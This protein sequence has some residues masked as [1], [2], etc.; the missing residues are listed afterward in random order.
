MKTDPKVLLDK[1]K[2]KQLKIVTP[3]AQLC[4]ARFSPDGKVLVAGSF[5]GTVR[6]FDPNADAFTELPE[7][8]I[9][10][11]FVQC[12][13]FH[14]DSQRLFSADSW[15][16]ITC[17]GDIAA[18]ETKTL[19]ALPEAHGTWVRKLALSPDGTTLASASLDKTIKLWSVADGKKIGEFAVGADTL[20]V[21]FHPNGKSI[22]SGDLFGMVREWDVASSKSVREFDAKVFYKLDRIQDVGGVRCL[23]FSTDGKTLYAAGAQPTTGGFV[24]GIPV[25][26]SFDWTT[27][28]ATQTLKFGADNEGYIHD[29][30]WHPD[31]FLMLATSGQPGVGKLHF[32]QPDDE[33]P[34]F[35]TSFPNSH[36]VTLHPSGKRLVVS[37]TNANSSGNGRVK[38]KTDKDYPANNSPLHVW[39]MG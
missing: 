6:R 14:P 33:K 34:F 22:V 19:W 8:K 18:K 39:Q 7:L 26:M 16:N 2:P 23:L 10:H 9:H 37:A 12:L 38:G 13:V 5:V 36:A 17:T 31:G 15:G 25:L 11:A 30:V 28:K 35:T 20:S 21:A 27:G 4:T 3:D 24:Q 29:L 1:Y 32:V